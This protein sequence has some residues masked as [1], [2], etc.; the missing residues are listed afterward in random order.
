MSDQRRQD[1]ELAFLR[2]SNAHLKS[3]NKKLRGQLRTNHEVG[4]GSDDIASE[5][6]Q[7]VLF[8]TSAVKKQVH[9][10]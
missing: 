9:S 4:I 8:V 6:S 7:E 2:Q 3:S 1:I 5:D 10:Q